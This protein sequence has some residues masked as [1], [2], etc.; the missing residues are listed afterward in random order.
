MDAFWDARLHPRRTSES[1][2]KLMKVGRGH[3]QGP[4]QGG[5]KLTE[6]TRL[7]NIHTAARK[8]VLTGYVTNPF[9]RGY[10]PTLQSGVVRI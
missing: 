6:M 1:H 8:H 2:G 10:F 5:V 4:T 3:S 9:E 7:I